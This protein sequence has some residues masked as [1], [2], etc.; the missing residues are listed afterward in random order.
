MYKAGGVTIHIIEKVTLMGRA[1][2][3]T[4]ANE[5]ANIVDGCRFHNFM[6]YGHGSTAGELL[7]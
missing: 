1:A 3:H 4:Q 6:G 5:T 7:L 2:H